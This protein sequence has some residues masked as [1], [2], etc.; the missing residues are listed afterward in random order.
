M[1]TIEDVET[2]ISIMTEEIQ[3][4]KETYKDKFLVAQKRIGLAKDFCDRT[5]RYT[6]YVLKFKDEI[7]H[8]CDLHGHNQ[9][10][11][12]KFLTELI[13]TNL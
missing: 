4:L 13:R 12:D 9:E 7:T 2:Q 6:G 5:K 11:H 1:A 10:C 8:Y 3:D